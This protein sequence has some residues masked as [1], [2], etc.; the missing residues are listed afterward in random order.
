MSKN[1]E[2]RN[3]QEYNMSAVYVYVGG[4]VPSEM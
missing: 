1:F 4:I 2:D 3:L